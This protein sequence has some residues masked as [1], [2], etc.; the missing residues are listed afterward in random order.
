M[1]VL[2]LIGFLVFVLSVVFWIFCAAAIAYD[3]LFYGGQNIK[4][5]L[6][7]LACF[8]ST[9]ALSIIIAMATPIHPWLE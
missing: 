4:T 6:I 9:L 8:G 1:T 7:A 2:N 5:L 3:G